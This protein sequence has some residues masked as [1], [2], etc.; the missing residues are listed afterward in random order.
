ME[1]MGT[2]ETALL[3]CGH[4]VHHACY[5]QAR[6]FRSGGR[7]SMCR[8]PVTADAPPIVENA[9]ELY[10]DPKTSRHWMPDAT[11]AG[12]HFVTCEEY[13]DPS[14][15]QIWRWIGGGSHAYWT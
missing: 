1:A 5:D 3:A 12:W 8:R 7:C 11:P 13:V 14:S 2:E 6:R 15:G 4:R 10:L 9:I